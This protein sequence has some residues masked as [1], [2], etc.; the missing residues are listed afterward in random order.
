MS[1]KYGHG[2]IVQTSDASRRLLILQ[3]ENQQL[4]EKVEKYEKWFGDN[5]TLLTVYKIPGPFYKK[6]TTLFLG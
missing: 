1:N 3:K 6:T 5:A 2:D 4:R